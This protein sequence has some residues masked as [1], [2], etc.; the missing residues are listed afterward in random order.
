MENLY[1]KHKELK[2]IYI[3]VFLMGFAEG[4]IAIFVPVYLYSLNYPI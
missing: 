3:S 4:M 2:L 1:Q